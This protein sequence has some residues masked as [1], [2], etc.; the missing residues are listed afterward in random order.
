MQGLFMKMEV[1][2]MV[3]MTNKDIHALKIAKE[4]PFGEQGP[5]SASPNGLGDGPS[6]PNVTERK[7]HHNQVNVTTFDEE[8]RD[9]FGAVYLEI[10]MGQAEFS[11]EFQVLDI[12]TSYNLLLGRLWIHMVG[13][14]PS[15]LHQLMKFVWKDQVVLNH[16]P[17]WGS[18]FKELLSLFKFPPKEKSLVWEEFQQFENQHKPNLEETEI[19]NLG[20]EECVRESYRDMPGLSINMNSHKMPINPDFSSI[21]Q[22]TL[23]FKPKLS[24]KIKEEITKQIKSKVVEVMQYPTWLAN[25]VSIAKKDRNIKICVYY[26]D[27]NKASSK[28]NFPLPNIHI[29]IDKCAKH[30]MQSFVL[31]A[32]L[33]YIENIDWF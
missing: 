30:E 28:D 3:L 18:A 26:R 2:E 17:D 4:V 23:K 9:T 5:L 6:L 24:L 12:N 15:T 32:I 33:F 10:Q 16:D 20:D 11:V 27:L 25:I 14:L 7:I 29:L 1:L 22:K 21:K 8:K 19:V 13:A 31:Y